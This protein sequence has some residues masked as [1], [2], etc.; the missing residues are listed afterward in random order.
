MIKGVCSL[1]GLS[2][3]DN[4]FRLG[5]ESIQKHTG[6]TSCL[7]GTS[8]LRKL[9]RAEVGIS[10]CDSL[11]VYG[12]DFSTNGLESVRHSVCRRQN[13]KFSQFVD[14]YVL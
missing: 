3:E 11:R 10:F 7:E 13:H 8:G 1:D 6:A 5:M 4:L 2:P 12:K 9:G 14:P